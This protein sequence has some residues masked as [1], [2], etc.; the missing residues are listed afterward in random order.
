M[1]IHGGG[2][3]LG[4][5]EQGNAKCSHWANEIDLLVASV[6]YRL[7]PEHPFPAALDDC[8]G[9]LCWL[10]DNADDLGVDRSRIAV[11]GDSAGGMLAAVLC[12]VARPRQAPI[13]FQ[14]SNTRCSTTARPLRP[15]PRTRSFVDPC[16]Q[17]VRVDV[18]PRTPPHPKRRPLPTPRR[19]APPT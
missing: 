17:P 18:L 15:P 2:T 11:G 13:C 5:P 6:D 4:S 16:R 9:A 3:V 12:Q 8:Y 1:W 7:A 10:H 14:L 19:H